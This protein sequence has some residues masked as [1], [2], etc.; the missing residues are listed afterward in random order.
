[1]P[2]PIPDPVL[3]NDATDPV[4]SVDPVGA[5]KQI[6]LVADLVPETGEVAGRQQ[7][8]RRGRPILI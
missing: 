2:S 5:P 1:V 4:H 8:R 6:I 3:V 7:E